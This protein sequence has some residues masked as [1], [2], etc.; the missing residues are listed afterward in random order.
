[1]TIAFMVFSCANIHDW[2]QNQYD[3]V[4]FVYVPYEGVLGPFRKAP[5]EYLLPSSI[6]HLIHDDG[7]GL[8]CSIVTVLF[9]ENSINFVEFS[10]D[11]C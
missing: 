10:Y 9:H 6:E 11:A 4:G 7:R 1:M 2:P 5:A 3:F 8:C